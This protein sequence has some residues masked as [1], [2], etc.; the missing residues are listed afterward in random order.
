MLQGAFY[1][2]AQ[3]EIREISKNET[4]HGFVVIDGKE[5]MLFPLIHRLLLGSKSVTNLFRYE[6]S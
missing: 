5:K 1:P 2:E 6:S 3:A 4:E